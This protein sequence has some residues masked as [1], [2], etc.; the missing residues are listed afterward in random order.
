MGKYQYHTSVRDVTNRS[1]QKRKD[2]VSWKKSPGKRHFVQPILALEQQLLPGHTH[3]KA[4]SGLRHE[5]LTL[6]LSLLSFPS[7]RFSTLCHASCLPC[8]VFDAHHGLCSTDH[9]WAVHPGKSSSEHCLSA[10]SGSRCS[11]DP[12]TL[13]PTTMDMKIF[14]LVLKVSGVCLVIPARLM[15]RIHELCSGRWKAKWKLNLKESQQAKWNGRNILCLGR[16]A[17]S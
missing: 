15:M 13:I 2:Y 6:T 4:I 12:L 10:L 17:A 11:T 8:L 7:H 5:N 3:C 9:H 1:A 16:E 14:R